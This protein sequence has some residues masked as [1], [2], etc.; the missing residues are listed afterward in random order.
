MIIRFLSDFDV[1]FK[2]IYRSNINRYTYK[3]NLENLNLIQILLI[4]NEEYKDL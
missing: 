3:V 1:I 4:I 2:I